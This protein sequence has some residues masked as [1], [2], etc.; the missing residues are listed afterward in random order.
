MP[1]YLSASELLAFGKALDNRQYLNHLHEQLFLR[2]A[3]DMAVVELLR[4]LDEG[5][6]SRLAAIAILADSAEGAITAHVFYHWR[7]LLH[8]DANFLADLYMF[9]LGRD[10]DEDGRAF[11][12]GQLDT[13]LMTRAGI[14][15]N[16]AKG[17]E[18]RARA[19]SR[20]A[21]DGLTEKN[22]RPLVNI[23]IADRG[24]ILERLAG[25]IEQRLPYVTVGVTPGSAPIQYF[26][27]YSA[28]R[29]AAP[30]INMA[31][32]THMEQDPAMRERFIRA[33]QEVDLAI[34]MSDF[35]RTAVQT[36]ARRSV[37][38]TPGVDPHEFPLAPL[39]IGVAGRTYGS[40]R[41]G[42]ALVAQL[43]DLPGIEWHFSGDG[44]PGPCVMYPEHERHAFFHAIDY[45]LV[46][47]LYEGGPMTALEALSC[48]KPL[49]APEVG[50]VSE[51]PHIS[52]PTGDAVAVRRIL[53]QLAEERSARSRVVQRYSWNAWAH[54]HH[55][56]FQYLLTGADAVP[57]ITKAP[58]SDV[59]R[60]GLVLHKPEGEGRTGGPS[61]RA[62]ETAAALNRMG[63]T[64][65]VHHGDL[66]S[67]ASADLVHL[68][69]VWEPQ[70]ATQLLES[71]RRRHLPTVFSSIFIDLAMD[72]VQNQATA[73]FEEAR[74]FGQVEQALA[75]LGDRHREAMANR[76]QTISHA[77][78]GYAEQVQRMLDLTDHLVTT[79]DF[80]FNLLRTYGFDLPAH[81]IVRNA[82]SDQLLT[83][84][85]TN[86]LP[87]VIAEGGYILCLGNIEPRKNQL[88]LLHACRD[89]D[90]PLVLAGGGGPSPYGKLVQRFMTPW[91]HLTGHINDDR[92][93]RTIIANA[94]AFVLPSWAEGA[95]LSALD[96]GALGIPLVLS[97]QSSEREYFGDH[98]YYC[99][100]WDV[101]SM[102]SALRQALEND[103]PDSRLRRA[104]FV[105]NNF[106]YDRVA[107][108]LSAIYAR[109][110]GG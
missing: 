2:S 81:S 88:L 16:I 51:L 40:G 48:G 27:P 90:R 100:P 5:T 21:L 39:R 9:L 1:K 14:I 105:R 60:A 104:T 38:I 10:I 35:Y 52:Y 41:K 17:E 110:T 50:F 11:Y 34:Y 32:F 7:D 61:R 33:C 45:L 63:H 54:Q 25:E 62:V 107:D 8:P 93:L 49:I 102:Q 42:E 106:N 36:N 53:V 103:S 31:L 78:P 109:I 46:P 85:P 72:G 87:P 37:R 74:T 101:D 22:T 73:A 75:G 98:G 99:D 84:E 86:R 79:S 29:E 82:A 12:Q 44:W 66:P 18:C 58:R 67:P 76:R 19:Q 77:L 4:Q 28:R 23:V 65:I 24:W 26:L 95:P 91:T 56:Q 69:N 70:S 108:Q 30:G 94:A 59:L 71:A 64:A 83:A 55:T 80:E 89:L 92:L 97:S 68:F 6:V 13:S 20:V 96:A 47:S 57:D 3:E 15:L 43:M